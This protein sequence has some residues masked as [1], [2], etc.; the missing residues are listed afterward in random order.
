MNNFRLT[1]IVV[2]ATTLA[3]LVLAALLQFRYD[4]LVTDKIDPRAPVHRTI[5][6]SEVVRHL[7]FGFNAVLADYYWVTAVQAYLKWDSFDAYYPEYFK[8]ISALDPHFEYPYLFAILTVPTKIN[9]AS[10]LWLEQVA[11]RGIRAF[12][13]NYQI[14]FSAA[15]QFHI[16]GKDNVRAVYFLGIASAIGGV[17][18]LVLRTQAIYLMRDATDYDKSRSLFE[19]ILATADNEETKK[20]VTERIL[21]LD[22]VEKLEQAV[23]GYQIKNGIYPIT[24]EELISSF[25]LGLPEEYLA[26]IN[27]FRPQIEQSTG[28]II[29]R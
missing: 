2:P 18:E 1:K 6:P 8:I 15:T 19:V 25:A 29:L 27:K 5:M 12:P 23:I 24:V 7:A 28:K 13:Q 16:V 17:P 4:A 22:L 14:P 26:L 3:L 20:I 10:L 9:P 21:L 11:N